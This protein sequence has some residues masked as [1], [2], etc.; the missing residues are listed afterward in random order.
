MTSDHDYIARAI[1]QHLYGHLERRVCTADAPM[2]EVD[3][4][5]YRWSHPDA[6]VI[7]RPPTAN[8]VEVCCCPHCMLTFTSFPRPQ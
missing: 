3:K 5:R 8:V 7:G 1:H 4:D 6:R 2:P